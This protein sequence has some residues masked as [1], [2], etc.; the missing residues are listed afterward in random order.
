VRGE[1]A[2]AAFAG[3]PRVEK[4][5]QGVRITFA[6]KEPTDVGVAILDVKG[7]N[8]YLYHYGSVFKFAPEA[9]YH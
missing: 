2:A 5:A 9:A 1:T 8:F 4:V 3:A 6:V 7:I